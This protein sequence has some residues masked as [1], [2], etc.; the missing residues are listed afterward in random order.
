[1]G[2]RPQKMHRMLQ[3]AD[4]HVKLPGAGAD[5]AGWTSNII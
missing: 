2:E 4:P 5:C 3:H 1:M